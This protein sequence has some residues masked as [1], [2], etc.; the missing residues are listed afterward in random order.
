MTFSDIDF[1]IVLNNE[2][3]INLNRRCLGY[4]IGH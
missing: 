2:L 1:W 4:E 3:F